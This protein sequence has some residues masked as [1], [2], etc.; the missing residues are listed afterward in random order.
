MGMFL[1]SFA[2]AFSS[3]QSLSSQNYNYIPCH[4]CDASQQSEK[5]I[6]WGVNNI[7]DE[8]AHIGKLVPVHVLD[9]ERG[10]VE[11][12]LLLKIQKEEFGK[13]FFSI[14]KHLIESPLELKQKTYKAK[15]ATETLQAS[16]KLAR[17][18]STVVLDPWEFIWCAY[19]VGD[20]ED[21]FNSTFRS[22][23]I[24]WERVISDIDTALGISNTLEVRITL[25]FMNGGSIT[26]ST[27][28]N[29]NKPGVEVTKVLSVLDESNN[30]IPLKSSDAIGITLRIPNATRGATISESLNTWDLGLPKEAIGLVDIIKCPKLEPENC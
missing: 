14:E 8:Y 19:C 6:Y 16:V 26:F 18:P 29:T 9:F 30:Q 13:R 17:I 15:L 4:G 7:I 2:I 5:I 12:Y 22:E 10:E 25:E 21:F 1:L 20:I 3:F 27:R 28:A 24:V 23:I 11:S